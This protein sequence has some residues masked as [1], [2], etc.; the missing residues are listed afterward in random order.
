MNNLLSD[1]RFHFGVYGILIKNK[2]VLMIKKSRGPYKGMYDLPGGGIEFGEKVEEALKREFVE[3]AG[4]ELDGLE[5]VGHN[6]YFSEYKNE[7]NELR[8][9]HHVGLYYQVSATYEFIKSD[10]DGQD[11]LGAEFVDINNLN[12]INIAPIAKPMI[13]KVISGMAFKI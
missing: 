4:I 1:Q 13:M 10:A 7:K 5:F 8:K 12:N 2:E 9:M 3:E 11:S 6:E